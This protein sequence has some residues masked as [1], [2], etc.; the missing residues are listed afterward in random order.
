MRL[1]AKQTTSAFDGPKLVFAIAEK[2]FAL[3][4]QRSTIN[5]YEQRDTV[6]GN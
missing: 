2:Q 1:T 4:G 3:V 5:P 6:P